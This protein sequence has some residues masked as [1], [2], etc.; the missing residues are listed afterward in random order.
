MSSTGQTG[1]RART[2]DYEAALND[3]ADRGVD[4]IRNA[5]AGFDDAVA[6]ASQKGREAVRGA[7]EM[8]DD[9]SDAILEQVRTRPYTTLAIVGLI[10]FLYGA[11]RRR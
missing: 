2:A 9:V 7:R 5:K 6:D 8:R 11:M 10:G 1:S 4:A 3:I